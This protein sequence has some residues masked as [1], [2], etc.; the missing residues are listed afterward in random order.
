MAADHLGRD[1]A[2]DILDAELAFARAQLRLKDD[3]KEQI[4]ELLAVLA[5]VVEVDGFEDFVRFLDEEGLERLESL[6]AIPRAAVGC[7]QLLHDVDELG[8]VGSALRDGHRSS[9]FARLRMRSI[10]IPG[11]ETTTATSEARER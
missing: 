7:Q 2:H 4:A 8:K 6:L 9:K 11:S 10:S 5:R 1:R 3:L